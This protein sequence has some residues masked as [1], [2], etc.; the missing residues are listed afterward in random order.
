MVRLRCAV[1]ELILVLMLDV[2]LITPV[3]ALYFRRNADLNASLATGRH[4][5]CALVAGRTTNLIN[6]SLDLF[7]GNAQKTLAASQH[8]LAI[9]QPFP[10]AN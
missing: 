5:R 3:N 6:G 1:N 7:S 2:I 9:A 10:L 4:D 8:D